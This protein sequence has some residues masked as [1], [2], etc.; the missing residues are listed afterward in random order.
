MATSE[1]VAEVI[2]KSN[3]ALADTLAKA[4]QSLKFTRAPK[5]KLSKLYG[6]PERSGDITLHEWVE[7][8]DS[9]CRQL[10]L[11]AEEQLGVAIDHLGG[12]AKD[13][14]LCT[15]VKERD[16]LVKVI[17]VLWRIFGP[18]ETIASLT[19]AL[20]TRSQLNDETLSEFSRALIQIQERMEQVAEGAELTAL[21]LMRDE[22]LKERFV[23]GASDPTIRRELRRMQI[24]KPE[25]T[26]YTFREHVLELFPDEQKAARKT[27]V[28][29]AANFD[30][31]DEAQVRAVTKKDDVMTKLVATNQMVL[32]KLDKSV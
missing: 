29:E 18:S 31:P 28:R 32:E 1:E 7:E 27:R 20:Y 19:S 26:F 25:L 9:Y 24:E 23:Q 2:A 3:A 11:G 13:E 10:E 6:P 4:F 8:L 16:T 17:S 30:D 14:V 22:V 15:P 21:Q 5:L 12:V